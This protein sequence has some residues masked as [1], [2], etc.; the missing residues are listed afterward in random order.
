MT[1]LVK[2]VNQIYKNMKKI[3]K[4]TVKP[5]YVVDVTDCYD[6]YDFSL[7]FAIAKQK[8]GQPLTDENLDIICT[9]A[10]DSLLNALSDLG[11]INKKNHCIEIV[12]N[13]TVCDCRKKEPWYKRFWKW[14]VG[15]K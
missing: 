15:R 5:A 2:I 14:L 13:I 1:L 8:A 12:R 10:V 6:M 3:I 4:N 11:A 9:A 7:A